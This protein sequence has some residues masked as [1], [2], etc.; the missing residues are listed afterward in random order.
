MKL[1]NNKYW[2]KQLNSVDI[3]LSNL[4]RDSYGLETE[5]KNSNASDSFLKRI[6][7]FY[8]LSRSRI[9]YLTKLFKDKAKNEL[10]LVDLKKIKGHSRVVFKRKMVWVIMII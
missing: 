10:K 4:K 1:L 9:K 3:V 6:N 8:F 5:Q 2:P 7:E